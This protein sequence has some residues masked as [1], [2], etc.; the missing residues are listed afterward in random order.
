MT[1]S[2]QPSELA[3]LSKRWAHL[4]HSYQIF[5]FNSRNWRRTETKHRLNRFLAARAKLVILH[6]SK[7]RGDVR[8]SKP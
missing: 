8:S 3:I 7:P 2:N 4:G 1:S 6:F 5:H